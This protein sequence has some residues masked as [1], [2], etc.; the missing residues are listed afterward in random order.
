[1][2]FKEQTI[3]DGAGIQ[4]N[5]NRFGDYAQMTIDPDGET[6]WY[7]GEY[8]QDEDFWSTRITAFNL[9]NLP[10]L[11]VGA[12]DEDK[13]D[14]QIYPLSKTE[15]EVIVLDVLSDGL[16]RYDILDIKGVVVHSAVF[17]ETTNG[18]KG[19]F[20]TSAISDG[21][22]IVSINNTTGSLSLTKKFVLKQ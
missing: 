11:T 17:S 16:L 3:I 9:D 21:I 14:I 20:D 1:M 10:L 7:V 19:Q 18:F 5:T 6:F 8:F 13:A 22:F 2:S 12:F 15:M 4:T